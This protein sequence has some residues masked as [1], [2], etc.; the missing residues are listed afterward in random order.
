MMGALQ[1]LLHASVTVMAASTTSQKFATSVFTAPG[2][3]P[4]TMF[5]K[6]YNNPTQ[7]A[8]QVQPLVKDPVETGLVYPLA[9]TSPDTIPTND[10]TDPHPLPPTASSSL[11]LEQAFNQIIAISTNPTFG[12]NNCARCQAGLGVAKFLALAS[13]ENG[14]VL[15]VRLC[16]HFK[17]S[18]SCGTSFSRLALGSVITQVVANANVGGYDGQMLCQNFINGLCPLPPA[19]PLNLTSWFTKPKP[20]PIPPPKKPSGK[21]LKVLH[22]SDFHLDPRYA[23]GAEANCTSGLCCRSHGFNSASPNTTL[24]PAP[25]FGA[26]NCDTPLALGLAALQAIPVLTGAKGTGF[27]FTVYT[28]DLV[29]HDPDNQL[30]RDYVTYTET[31]VFDLFKRTL[32]SGPV[33]A[34]LGNHDSYNQ[35]QDAHHAL[36]DSLAQQFQ[37][38]YDHLAALWQHES[39]LPAAAVALARAHYSAYM[40]QRHDGFRV[41]CLNTD[42]WYRANYFNYIQLDTPDN[43]GMLRFLTDELQDAEDAGD[44]VWIIGHVLSGWDGSNPLVN[45]TDLFYQIIDRYSPHV[46]ANVF[47]GHTHEDQASQLHSS[48]RTKSEAKARPQSSMPTTQPTSAQGLRKPWHGWIGPSLTP[49][50]HLNSGFR[51]Y[52]VDSSTFDIMNAYTWKSDVNTFS[53]LDHQLEFGPPYSFEYSTRDTYGPS[54]P[55]WTASDPLNATFWHLVTEAMEANSSLVAT[56]N[57]LQGK[58]SVLTAPCTGDCVKAKICYL[59][60]G[61]AAIA[62]QN[63]IPGFG[64]RV[65]TAAMIW[66]VFLAGWNDG[67]LGPLIPRIQEVYHLGYIIVALLFVFASLGA[68]TG[69]ILTINL[70]PKLGFGKMLLLAPLFQIIGYSLQSAALPYPVFAFASFL[71]SIG[72]CMLDAQANGYVANIARNGE[73][74]M[75]YTQAAYGAGLFAAPLVSTQFAQIHR[76]SF[77]YLVSLGITLSNLIILALVFR[78]RSQAECLQSLGQEPAPTSATAQGEAKNNHMRA[79]FTVKALHLMALFLFVHVGVGVANGGWSVSYMIN[80]RGGGAQSGYIA[81]GYSGGVVLGRIVLIPLNKLIGENRVVYVYT[82]IAIGLQLVVWLVPSLVGDAI[83]LAFGGMMS[84]PLYPLA[85]NRATRLF[86]SH[87]LTPAMGW[88][89]AVA[90]VGGA[91][92]PFIAGAISSRAGIKSLQPVIVA[93]MAVMLILWTLVPQAT[94]PVAEEEKRATEVKDEKHATSPQREI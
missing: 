29:S 86:R 42:M 90:T 94:A 23:T 58:S 52:E 36:G 79:L 62:K 63:C 20:N 9:L 35:A 66:A 72:V 6:Y 84:G 46:V 89:A 77:H 12:S 88:M 11:L 22:V 7:T 53:A 37:W 56:F 40:V 26:F 10:T 32:G 65:H 5:T 82:L 28:G 55:G 39:W 70:T 75:G 8:S 3:F 64:T 83:A 4:T 25:R 67:T 16:E 68:I 34:A 41:I 17:F 31:V 45:P 21:L 87:L 1:L 18:S 50:N 60:S 80:V 33:Y 24:F 38:N 48:F 14:P 15:A 57:T 19:T 47:F 76:W 73:A 69:A 59:R 93:G 61:S 44:R 54:V 81:A 2:R 27:D 91:I 51:M 92:I 78:G 74:R 13:P 43:S 30:S 85:L 49:L 71:N